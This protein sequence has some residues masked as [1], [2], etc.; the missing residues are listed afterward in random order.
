MHMGSAFL[1]CSLLHQFLHAAH[2]VELANSRHHQLVQRVFKFLFHLS[3]V[4]LAHKQRA[5][6]IVDPTGG[7]VPILPRLLTQ[8][9]P[10]NGITGRQDLLGRFAGKQ[11]LDTQNLVK[12]LKLLLGLAALFG[13]QVHAIKLN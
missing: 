13:V 11:I 7:K 5:D 8:L 9:M 2:I 12:Q 10:P 6:L 3:C 4:C 1:L